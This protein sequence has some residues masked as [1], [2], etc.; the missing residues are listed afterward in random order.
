M[1]LNTN[2]FF[3]TIIEDDLD[4][5]ML[6]KIELERNGFKTKGIYTGREALNWISKNHNDKVFYI[7]DYKLSD[8]DAYELIE[9]IKKTYPDIPF[10]VLTGK[11]DEKVAVNMMKMGAYDYII[12]DASFNKLLSSRLSHAIEQLNIKKEL[13]ENQKKII[14]SE[15]KYR[16]IF[17]NIQDVFFEITFDGNIIEISPSVQAMFDYERE[18]L[19]SSVFL[20]L[21]NNAK[22]FELFLN[23]LETNDV[24]TNYEITLKT[25]NNE[26]KYCTITCKTIIYPEHVDKLIIG[27]IRDITERKK[28]ER[29]ILNKIIETEEKEKKKFAD[30][31]HDGLGPILATIKMYVDLI[32]QSG[33]S[34]NLDKKN[35]VI[36]NIYDL[37]DESLQFTKSV[38]NNL[39]PNIISEYGLIVA[40]K[41]FCNKITLTGKLNISLEFQLGNKRLNQILEIMLYRII[42]ELIN[43]TIKHAYA[44]K[45]YVKIVQENNLLNVSY[46]DDGIGFD[47]DRILNYPEIS[48]GV[49]LI[50]VVN[51][52]K[53]FN[54]TIT[55]DTKEQSKINIL[56][57]LENFNSN[58]NILQ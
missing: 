3:I 21:L 18:E 31:L 52:L 28:V 57:D 56:L 9:E 27:T 1:T 43:N 51:R 39:M 32:D 30:E 33:H 45:I 53:S 24:I 34:K 6:I 41:S 55:F 19:I 35:D 26:I 29:L 20:N 2:D 54:G 15:S 23:V 44:K 38:A 42:I 46:E 25:K 49:G 7:F 40:I 37:I 47:I 4:L 48:D 10:I 12:K 11:G 36:Q 5:N 16:S 8:M 22:D 17:E 13:A 58:Y 50:N 14:L